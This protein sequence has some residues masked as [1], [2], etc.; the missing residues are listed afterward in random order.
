M[1]YN[2]KDKISKLRN[3]TSHNNYLIKKLEHY[4][5]SDK[6]TVLPVKRD[7]RERIV[8]MDALKYE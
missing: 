3:I 8:V 5:H 6:I 1:C 7:K 4:W 2:I